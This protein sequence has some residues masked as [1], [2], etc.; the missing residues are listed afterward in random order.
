MPRKSPCLVLLLLVYRVSFGRKVGISSSRRKALSHWCVF[1]RRY[2]QQVVK[3]WDCEFRTAPCE[4]RISLLYLANDIMQNTRKETNGGY[5]TEFMRVIPDA[6][7]EVF[8]NGD[9]PGRVA[10]K[11]LIRLL[12]VYWNGVPA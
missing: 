11:R 4:R 6:L 5:I 10:V 9:G 3:T 2:C 1:H 12:S 8:N 7:N